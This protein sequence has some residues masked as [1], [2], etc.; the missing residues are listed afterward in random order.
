LWFWR[1]RR[2]IE[3][4]HRTGFFNDGVRAFILYPTL[5]VLF[6]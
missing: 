5:T 4:R 3:I 1:K 2:K 6:S